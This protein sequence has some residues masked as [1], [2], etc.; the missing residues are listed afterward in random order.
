MN[1]ETRRDSGPLPIAMRWDKDRTERLLGRVHARIDRERR[2]RRSLLVGVPVAV[3]ALVVAFGLRHDGPRDMAAA[4]GPAGSPAATRVVMIGDGSR[5]ELR[6]AESTIRVR[7]GGPSVVRVDLE[8]GAGR[9]HVVRDP[10]RTFEVIAGS[11]T[12]AVV[13]TEFVVE[14]RGD[15]A[16][17][18]VDSGTV[19]V[20]WPD[21]SQE[22]SIGQSGLFPPAVAGLELIAP[23]G[24]ADAGGGTV[25]SPVLQA[26]RNSVGRRDYREAYSVLSRHPGVVGDSID[27][28]LTAADVARLSGHGAEAVP[29]LERVEA[30][31]PRDGRAPLAAFT[32]GRTLL[33][34]GRAR[35]AEQTFA[36]VR[37]RWPKSPLAEDALVRQVEAAARSGDSDAARRLAQHYDQAYPEGRRRSE[38]RRYAG[39]E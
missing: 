9:F 30:A 35:E 34:L 15:R 20:S 13:G 18:Q 38:A 8:S 3:I 32:L 28:L 16:W 25:A 22:L 24:V 4:A 36:R 10:K 23:S 33:G 27:D 6:D 1:D 26:Y 5:V 12:V 14:L 29:Y 21:D 11:V 39:L 17:V 37:A 19:R 2:L 31:N 7:P